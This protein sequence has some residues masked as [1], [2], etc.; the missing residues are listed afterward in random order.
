MRKIIFYCLGVIFLASCTLS[1]SVVIPPANVNVPKHAIFISQ[2]GTEVFLMQTILD[3]ENN[4][5]V[6]LTYKYDDLIR[7]IRTGVLLNPEDY[8]NRNIKGTDAPVG[9]DSDNSTFI[10]HSHDQ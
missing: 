1:Q 4:E 6:V 7:V 2:S 5:M 10:D 9:E 3:L 8:K